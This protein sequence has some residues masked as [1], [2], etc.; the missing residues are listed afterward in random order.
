M[1]VYV[2]EGVDV[3]KDRSNEKRVTLT[4]LVHST[5]GRYRCEVSTEGPSFDTVSQ[6]GDLL[7]VGENFWQNFFFVVK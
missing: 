5:T 3:D 2:R 7:V 4:N 6:Y 1:T